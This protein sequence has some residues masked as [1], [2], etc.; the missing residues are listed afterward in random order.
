MSQ[1]LQKLLCAISLFCSATAQA[2]PIIDQKYWPAAQASNNFYKYLGDWPSYKPEVLH[3]QTF[4]VVHTGTLIELQFIGEGTNPLTLEIRPLS[5]GHP[6]DSIVYQTV[7]VP[8]LAGRHSVTTVPL[9]LA[10]DAGQKLSFVLSGGAGGSIW[11]DEIYGS[12][13]GYAPGQAWIG[14]DFENGLNW[15]LKGPSFWYTEDGPGSEHDWYFR[16]V[17]DTNDP[18]SVPE[19]GTL[20]LSMLAASTLIAARLNRRKQ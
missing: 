7:A 14:N 9:H 10:V 8:S 15:G 2:T 19:P 12:V 13:S 6:D 18:A 1:S 17:V 4:E 3:T 5:N 20:Y 11:G 16:T